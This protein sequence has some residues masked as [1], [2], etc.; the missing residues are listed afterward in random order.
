MLDQDLQLDCP[1]CFNLY[2]CELDGNQPYVLI[3]GHTLCSDCLGKII[4]LV[5]PFCLKQQPDLL[6]INLNFVI[7]HE[8]KKNVKTFKYIFNSL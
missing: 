4:P 3:C 2:G 6:E 1:I 5:C 8:I 7:L